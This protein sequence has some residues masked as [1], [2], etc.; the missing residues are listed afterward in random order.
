ME[1]LAN[2]SAGTELKWSGIVMSAR[3]GEPS[4]VQVV[5][6]NE[7]QHKSRALEMR[8]PLSESVKREEEREERG[9]D[10]VRRDMV[11]G[12]VQPYHLWYGKP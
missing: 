2:R 10:I 9:G 11:T 1:V 12:M 5:A 8:E 3:L 6:V 4:A 7:E